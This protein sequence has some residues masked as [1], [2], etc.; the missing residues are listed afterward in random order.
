[1]REL[2]LLQHI[3]E[4]SGDLPERVRLGPG[5]D[6]A[7]LDL[8]GQR[9]LAAVDQLIEGRHYAPDTP[10]EL[11]GRKAMMRCLSDV[12]AMAARPVAAL[13]TAALPPDFGRARSERLF[14]AMRAAA[15]ETDCPLIGGDIA[16]HGDASH[17]L[18]CTVTVLAA[19]VGRVITR[20]GARV[21]D[22]VYVTGALGGA[23]HGDEPAHHLTFR[24]RLV[25]AVALGALLGER[26][27]AMIDVSDGLGRDA[28][29]VARASDVRLDIDATRL[30]CRAGIP[31]RRAAGE[32]EDYELLFTADGDV[33]STIGDDV[34]VTCIGRVVEHP[35][36]DEP[37]VILRDGDHAEPGDEW[38]WQH[39]S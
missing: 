26:L 23:V 15:V 37:R 7:L 36:G 39:E 29:N 13:A 16:L 18:V 21:G 38:G 30:P 6:M 17:P 22:S 19:P 31:W 35:G 1:V 5:D 32:G 14:D 27:H 3:Y 25:E 24:P 33:P 4:A 20:R 9:L 11:V 34:P 12:A 2:D 28:A 8:G 10:V